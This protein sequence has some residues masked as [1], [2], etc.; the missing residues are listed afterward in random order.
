MNKKQRNKNRNNAR[1]LERAVHNLKS[2]QHT[3]EE[4]G[5]KGFHW[6]ATRG[7]SLAAILSGVDDKQGF[8][9]CDK[10]YG[11]DGRRI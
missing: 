2:R 10:F 6:V 4:C 7:T 1:M 3:C 9:I 5:E 11:K 8:W